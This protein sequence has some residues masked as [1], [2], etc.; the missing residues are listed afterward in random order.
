MIPPPFQGPQHST[1]AEGDLALMVAWRGGR[2]VGSNSKHP[3]CCTYQASLPRDSPSNPPLPGAPGT[4]SPN[5]EGRHQRNNFPV[6]RPSSAN[7]VCNPD[8][9]SDR[10]FRQLPSSQRLFVHCKGDNGTA[11]R[12]GTLSPHTSRPHR[13]SGPQTGECLTE[14]IGIKAA[15][16]KLTPDHPQSLDP[17]SRP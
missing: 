16:F 9:V 11:D 8:L 7:L 5:L 6:L 3:Q 1:G 2:W 4:G 14:E 12:L 15:Q 17:N 13:R 10:V